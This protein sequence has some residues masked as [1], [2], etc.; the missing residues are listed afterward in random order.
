MS[1]RVA[2]TPERWK[3]VKSVFD[4]VLELPP[5]E[6]AAFLKGS[7]GFE[8]CGE[9]PEIRSEVESLLSFEEQRASLLDTPVAEVL[10]ELL[11][12]TSA[13]G[14]KFGPYRVE[15]EIGRGGMAVVYAA[16]RDD[17]QYRKQVAIKLI[18]RGMD[19][20]AII[21]RFRRERQILADLEHPNIARLLDG[22]MSEDG[23][24]Y[25][26][27]EFIEGVPI[28]VFCER[29]RL[30]VDQRLELFRTICGAVRYA[31][32]NL[33][34][35]RDLK[36]S[37]ILV[38]ATGDPK[39]LDFGIAKLLDERSSSQTALKTVVGLRPM[40]PEYASPEQAQGLPASTASDVYAL[41]V[42]LYR[43]LT[44]E[45]PYRFENPTPREI[46]RVICEQE[47]RRPSLA[48]AEKFSNRQAEASPRPEDSRHRRRLRR[49][50]VG[51]LDNIVL[52]ALHKS[53]ARRYGSVEQF[54]EDLRRHLVGQPVTAHQDT[55]AYR[56]GKFLARHRWGVAAAALILVSLVVGI[57]ATTHQ[58]RQA[59]AQKA[60]A[61]AERASAEWAVT[62]LVD[63][64]D[65]SRPGEARGETLTA[66]R[67]L[68]RGADRLK[69]GS[70]SPAQQ[71]R[72]RDG[73]GFAYFHL[74]V[75]DSAALH[76]EEA[77]DLRSQIYGEDALE[78]AVSLDHVGQLRQAQGELEEAD[79]LLSRALQLRQ[80]LL[81]EE[82]ELVAESAHNLALLLNA[83]QRFDRAEELMRHAL[84]L[85]QRLL[86]PERR[87]VA[88]TLN[89][90][91]LVLK[92]ANRPI[93]EV[94]SLYQQ[95]LAMNR[96]LFPE[97]SPDVAA[98]LNNLGALLREKG[99]LRSGGRALRGGLGDRASG[100]GRETPGTGHRRKPT[101][102]IATG[103]L[104]V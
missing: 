49:R 94:E 59:R 33:V 40:T 35:H 67:L 84:D 75:L 18:K 61:E 23:L 87:E 72:L 62:F 86:G 102:R 56:A 99:R 34:V 66:R 65:S 3:R 85:Q 10:A 29:Q 14:K 82:H 31:H 26:V 76:L 101:W 104:G 97:D 22:G 1:S 54:S 73:I 47:P 96:R 69:G 21:A 4:E 100:A 88:M 11:P 52:K 79:E 48:V 6:R 27:M 37:N 83:R 74:G 60:E 38:D 77:L 16:I 15:R 39:L 8:A 19:T 89:N 36:P 64:F 68:D 17:D 51:D 7:E 90:L 58:A 95:A 45:R 46:E 5:D 2:M 28:D 30:S 13:H 80:E 63:L 9:D 12:G 32:Q 55:L 44:G 57:V 41:G 43:L 50:L 78:T 103:C 93:E 71:A 91:A 20:D 25:L 42:L 24:P 81:G 53:P 92:G 98:N 70:E